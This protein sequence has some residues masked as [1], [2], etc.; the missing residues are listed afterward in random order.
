MKRVLILLLILIQTV[1]L[2]GCRQDG[3]SDGES[4]CSVSSESSGLTTSGEE[5]STTTVPAATVPEEPTTADTTQPT[6]P[7]IPDPTDPTEPTEPTEPDIPD[8]VEPTEP[9]EP[10]KPDPVEPPVAS[11]KPDDQDFVC[12]A[13]YIS[14]VKIALPY[15][16][17]NNFTGKRIYDFSDAYLRYGTVKKLQKV[18]E[19]LEQNGLG[20]I[21]WDGFRP[22]SAQAML[23]EACPDPTFVSNPLTGNRSHCRGNTVDVSLYDLATGEAVPVPTEFDDFTAAADR[24]YSDCSAEA[25]ANAILLEEIM[26]KCGFAPY[27]AEWWHFTD[28]I[29]YPV[30]ESFDPAISTAWTPNCNEYINLRE[31]PGGRVITKIPK[32]E[33]L[34]LLGWEDQ[35]AKVCY[36]GY[37]GYVMSNYIMPQDGSFSPEILD[38]VKPTDQ[39]SYRQMLA[40]LNEIA[41]RYPD[42]VTVSSIGTSELGLDIPVI[43]IGDLDAQNHVLVQGAIHG[44]EHLTAWL[45]VAMADYWLDHGLLGYGDVCYHIIP[46]VNPDGVVISQSQTLSDAQK[47]IYQSDRSNGYTGLKES[48]YASIWKANGLGVDINRNFP[49]GWEYVDD[50]FAPSSERY[51]G[52]SPFSTA[53]AAALRDYTLKY[54]FDATV[55]YHATGSIIYYEYGSKQ[56]VNSQSKSLANAVSSVSGYSLV[57]STDLDGAGY[58]DW[59]MD[60][61]GIP[62]ITV[63]IGVEGAPLSLREVYS[64]FARNIGA[65]PAIARWLQS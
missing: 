9:P 28:T 36:N 11:P 65:L 26:E 41:A 64:I 13:E 52:E 25:A 61:L 32:G 48:A 4:N 30:E 54:S 5:E 45:L 58:K 16:S 29:N 34:E 53:E 44:R 27:S 1:G 21:I 22:V 59:A 10:D 43:V 2:L 56:P 40:D 19:E 33:T 51:R 49:S 39:Y 24:D 42:A 14:N 37:K 7:D 35:Y 46:M 23:W 60:A 15:A 18:S 50:R 47:Q 31:A 12:I 57:R 62:S 8:P 55:S 38:T 6:E 17:E 63:E 20:L 3:I